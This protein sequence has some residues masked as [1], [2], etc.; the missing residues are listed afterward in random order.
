MGKPQRLIK[1]DRVGI[2]LPSSPVREEYRSR[3]NEELRDMGFIPVEVDS[4]LSDSGYTGKPPAE[5]IKDING[6]L[7]DPSLRAIMA[8]RGGYGSNLIL[9]ELKIER[10]LQPKLIIGSS[11]VSY[12][13]WKIMKDLEIPVFY[14]PMAYS[15]IADKR[16]DRENL[17]KTLTG[18]YDVIKIPGRVIRGGEA[19]KVVTGGCLSNLVS[20]CGTPHFPE[21]KDRIVLLEDTGERPYRLDRMMWQ[22]S[23]TGFFAGIKG[24]LLGE[25]PGCF[26]DDGE[27]KEFFS[28]IG[29]YFNAY[30]YPVLSDLPFGHASFTKTLP[31][32]INI[33]ISTSEFEGI[34]ISEK[35][36]MV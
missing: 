30:E 11:D 31:L 7:R 25:F 35:G 21:T 28:R 5:I 13:L 16:Y 17:I 20:L 29:K 22:L 26:K 24:L 34:L 12:L 18:D 27:K 32:G 8:A 2:F 23:Q 3:G 36:V 14:G 33:R 1:G 10:S 19:D 4:I 15:T 9:D 6:F